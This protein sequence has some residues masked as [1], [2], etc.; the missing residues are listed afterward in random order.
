[1]TVPRSTSTHEAD[2]LAVGEASGSMCS[3]SR[4]AFGASPPEWH[5]IAAVLL[6]LG[7]VLPV[8]RWRGARS[9]STRGVARLVPF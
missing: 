5:P 4:R 2:V 1:M 7:L 9:G 6:A 8:M 3:W